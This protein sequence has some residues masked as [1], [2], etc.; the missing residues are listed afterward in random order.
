MPERSQWSWTGLN[1]GFWAAVLSAI[2]SVWFIVAFG[3]WMSGMPAWTGIDAYVA[4]FEPVG[5]VAWVLPCFLLAIT[6]PVLTAAIYLY[7]PTDRRAPALVSLLFACI[8]GAILGAT[9]FLLGTV[10]KTAL[11]SGAVD[12]MELLVVGSPYSILN[13]L[14]GAGYLF[15]GMATV[16]AGLA[17]RVPGRWRRAT[18]WLL[19]LNGTVGMLGVVAGVLGWI[20]GSMLSLGVWAGTFPVATILLALRFKRDLRVAPVSSRV[21]RA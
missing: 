18:R 11:L 13:A 9:Y 7:L 15:M 6:F 17:W 2:W 4:R 12:G 21:I 5:Y 20:T 14:E 3:V 19:I 10:V 16:F 8:Y 1:T